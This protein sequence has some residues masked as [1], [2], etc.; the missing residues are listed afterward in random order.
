[1]KHIN[2][3]AFF[4]SAILLFVMSFNVYSEIS[5]IISC[6]VKA[7]FNKGV[8]L[9][10]WF[11]T[12]SAESVQFTYF[13]K[14]TFENL[15]EMGVDVIRLPIHFEHLSSGAPK[16][17]IDETVFSYLDKIIDWATELEIYLILDNHSFDYS[18]A[19][20]SNIEKRLKL[21]WTQ[22]A[23][24]YKDSSK[25]VL[26]EILNEP[27]GLD[28]L[29]WGKIQGR[30]INLIRSIDSA[31][32][33]IVG[34]ADYNSYNQLD[35][36]PVYKDENLI[37]TYHFYDPFL[38]THQG[39]EWTDWKDYKGVPFPWKAYGMPKMPDAYKGTWKE[40][41]I[42]NYGNMESDYSGFEK[43]LCAL[44]KRASEFSVKRNVPVF[45]GEFGV[46]MRYASPLYRASWYKSVREILEKSNIAWA[47]W[48]YFGGFGLF[49][50]PIGGVYP[51]DINMDLAKALGFTPSEKMKEKEKLSFPLYIYKDGLVQE[52]FRVENPWG[53]GYVAL[54]KKIED[55][56]SVI[57]FG[58]CA[59][60]GGLKFTSDEPLD[61]QEVYDND[62]FIEITL[63]GNIQ[64]KRLQ[65]RFVNPQ[66]TMP[67]RNCV[68]I[69]GLERDKN[70][71]D[72][73]YVGSNS[74]FSTIKIPLKNFHETGAWKESIETWYDT[75]DEFD[76]EE[77]SVI[78]IKAEFEEIKKCNVQIE[79]I[80]FSK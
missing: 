54:S 3:R 19:T 71:A 47:S 6:P 56:K 5:D 74:D 53:N 65:L 13:T 48:D 76:W 4:I 64:G 42:K 26:F 24:R 38:F 39:A 25:Y 63:R 37:Y 68:T 1:M 8:N 28:N 59:L 16:Y 10:M 45:C 7:P 62:G 36:L 78:E 58:D 23:T 2:V 67:W 33:I 75:E 34:G 40:E 27:H 57:E 18:K 72:V 11:E 46:L 9:S 73:Y 61:L 43:S 49:K 52:N 30:T 66:A 60:Y 21:I 50:S 17:V 69:S 55:G 35:S 77:V 32:T 70:K 51:N 80:K 29:K 44:M 22:V 12:D 79:E 20:P 14:K 15:K 31:H 41:Q